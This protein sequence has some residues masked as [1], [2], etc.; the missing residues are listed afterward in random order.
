[1]VKRPK[2]VRS[3]FS[4]CVIAGAVVALAGCGSGEVTDDTVSDGAVVVE[5]GEW[6]V[7]SETSVVA[8]GTVDFE[9]D[10][11]GTMPHEFVVVRTDLAPGKIPISGGVFDEGDASIEVIDEIVE[12]PAGETRQLSLDL[13]AGD[14]QLVCNLPGHY[15]LG[16]WTAFTVS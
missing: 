6:Y 11:V 12:W 4:A 14:Y 16:M 9:V 1:M 10:N 3:A 5:V 2:R 15:G 7:R 8:G 13:V